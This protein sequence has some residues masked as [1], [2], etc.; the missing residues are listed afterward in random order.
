MSKAIV[1]TSPPSATLVPDRPIPPLRPDTIRVRVVSVALNPT[2][3]KSC[4]RSPAGVSVGCDYA[5][6]VDEVGSAVTRPIRKGDRVCGSTVGCNPLHPE[7]GAFGEYVVAIAD[8]QIVI[9]ENLSFAEA[10]TLGTGLVTVG[11]A[12]YQSLKMAPPEDPIAT[13]ETVLIYGGS[14]ATGTL[15]IQYAKL[16]GYRVLT[17]CS[18]HSFALVKGLG[19]DGVW[20]YRD[21]GAAEAIREETQ[22]GLTLVLD[23]ISVESSAAFCAKAISSKG[24]DYPGVYGV[25]RGL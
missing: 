4:R 7:D 9:P 23:T 14:S 5:G 22:D 16:S 25:R 8:P 3:W 24:G 15:A 1:L 17:T 10:A 18:P 11:Q 21:A 13:P 19:A 12:L 6:I 20:D 2:D